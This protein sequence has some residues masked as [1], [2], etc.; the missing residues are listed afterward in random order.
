MNMELGNNSTS[1]WYKMEHANWKSEALFIQ[2][3]MHET[4]VI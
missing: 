4:E 2:F 3:K 1:S